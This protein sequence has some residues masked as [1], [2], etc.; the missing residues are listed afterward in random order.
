MWSSRAPEATG[1]GTKGTGGQKGKGT[2]GT[3]GPKGKGKTQ[4]GQAKGGGKDSE[5]PSSRVRSKEAEERRILRGFAR[6][7]ERALNRADEEVDREEQT[8]P[9]ASSLSVED[10]FRLHAR[11]AEGRSLGFGTWLG[12]D[13]WVPSELPS[14]GN[15]QTWDRLRREYPGLSAIAAE[16]R[17]GQREKATCEKWPH[18]ECGRGWASWRV[19]AEG[20]TLEAHLE[21]RQA[22]KTRLRTKETRG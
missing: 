12:E 21:A 8:A 16:N 2:K 7:A 11:P 14:V 20:P 19:R 15:N 3:S 22:T 6:R 10:A 1:K 17:A 18:R 13:A 4:K 9:A 5:K